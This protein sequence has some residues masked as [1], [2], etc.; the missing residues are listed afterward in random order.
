M[1][2]TGPTPLPSRVPSGLRSVLI[3]TASAGIAALLIQTLVGA[4]ISP[5]DYAVFAVF[6]AALYL[7]VGGLSGVQQEIV[8]ASRVGADPMPASGR[9]R[10]VVFAVG[11]AA[12]VFAILVVTGLGWGPLVFGGEWLEAVIFLSLG[13]AFSVCVAVATGILYGAKRWGLLAASIVADP[14]LRLVAVAL[15][16]LAG[17]T[18][19]QLHAAVVV[20]FPLVLVLILIVQSRR[21]GAP[22]VLDVGYRR[23]VWNASRTLVGAVATSALV[24]GFPLFLGISAQDE[25]QKALGTLLFVLTLTRAPIVIPLLALQSFLILTFSE[26]GSRLWAVLL[27]LLAAVAGGTLV[28]AILAALLAPWIL[29]VVFS[30]KYDINGLSVGLIVMSAGATAA[31]CASG[32]ATIA[33][34]QHTAFLVGWVV[35]AAITIG[36]VFVPLEL[37]TRTVVALSVGPLAGLAVH[38]V[39]LATHGRVARRRVSR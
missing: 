31:L 4:S 5:A 19:L 13:G 29:D 24:S 27:R 7:I 9:A 25:S 3:A 30:G 28:L 32:A 23:L 26:A 33:R 17:G 37:T 10:P 20:S 6:W 18:A 16:L 36:L 39:L 11:S 15:A 34:A 21:R 2:A 35:A 14:G 1:S 22:V 12:A 8:R 38:L